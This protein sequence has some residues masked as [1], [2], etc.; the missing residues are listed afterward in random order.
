MVHTPH[1]SGGTTTG[2]TNLWLNHQ[3][4]YISICCLNTMART[5]FLA[6]S[7]AEIVHQQTTTRLVIKDIVTIIRDNAFEDFE[8]LKELKL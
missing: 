1:T 4:K 7:S 5:K 2:V 6:E 3:R 8:V